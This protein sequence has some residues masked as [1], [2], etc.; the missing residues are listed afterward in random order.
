MNDDTKAKTEAK[1]EQS[2]EKVVLEDK[3]ASSPK[4]KSSKKVEKKVKAGRMQH[5]RNQ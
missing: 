4:A 1:P 5:D 2:E 3:P